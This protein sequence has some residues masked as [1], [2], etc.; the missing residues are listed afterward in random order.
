MCLRSGRGSDLFGRFDGDGVAERFELALESAGAV[1]DGVALALPVGSELLG[2]TAGSGVSGGFRASAAGGFAHGGTPLSA[3]PTED[4]LERARAARPA[5][6]G[7]AA[8]EA[9]AA[10]SAA[11]LTSMR[12]GS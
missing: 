9:I 12:S 10:A 3:T 6:H 1:L 7:Y 8:G 5:K 4:H 2:S 11:A